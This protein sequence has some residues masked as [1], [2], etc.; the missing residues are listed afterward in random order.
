MKMP[1][2]KY[3]GIE[4]SALPQ[5][6]LRWIVAN[7]DPGDI[8]EEARRILASPELRQESEAKSLEEQ[9][10]EILGEKPVGF[11]R[12]GRGKPRKRF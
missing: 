4:M 3:K 11:I 9:A 10:N 6:Y 7:F 5:D 8:R 2:G 12:R 1:F